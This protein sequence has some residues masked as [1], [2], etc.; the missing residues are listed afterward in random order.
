VLV[1]AAYGRGRVL[2]W[3]VAVVGAIAFLLSQPPVLASA[4]LPGAA[5]LWRT[6]AVWVPLRAYGVRDRDEPVTLG[7][8]F[9]AAQAVSAALGQLTALAAQHAP[10]PAPLADLVLDLAAWPALALLAAEAVRA[11][12]LRWL[13]C[14]LGLAVLAGFGLAEHVAAA[15]LAWLVA[16]RLPVA[17]RRPSLP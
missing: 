5:A 2:R 3:D 8:A 6:L 14:A 17:R 9:A 16:A 7:L 4:A 13:L 15:V 10:P 1:L 11:R 12:R